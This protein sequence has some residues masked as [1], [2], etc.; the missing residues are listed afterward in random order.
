MTSC[1][2]LLLLLIAVTLCKKN[3]K[4]EC[5]FGPVSG[6]TLVMSY[7]TLVFVLCTPTLWS[8]CCAHQGH[9]SYIMGV[10]VSRF[11]PLARAQH[12]SSGPHV[13]GYPCHVE[14]AEA[15]CKTSLAIHAT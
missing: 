5:Q 9:V 4:W 14:C 13:V 6:L 10:Y 15:A 1:C 3:R 8:L 7:L 11:I 12:V 2:Y